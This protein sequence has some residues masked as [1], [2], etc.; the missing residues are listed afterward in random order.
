MLQKLIKLPGVLITAHQ[1][2]ATQEALTNIAEATFYNINCWQNNQE[3]K[4]E[5]T[6]ELV[7]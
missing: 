2:F 1:A 3:S 6:L 4:N 7:G 5:L